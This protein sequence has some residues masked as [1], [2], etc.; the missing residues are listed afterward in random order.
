MMMMLVRMI[1]AAWSL[2]VPGLGG[3]RG[4]GVLLRLKLRARRCRGR[5]VG[6]RISAIPR[7]A[8]RDRISRPV[9]RYRCDR[10]VSGVDVERHTSR[11]GP[12]RGFS[13]GG[14]ASSDGLFVIVTGSFRTKGEDPELVRLPTRTVFEASSSRTNH[15]PAPADVIDIARQRSVQVRPY[16]VVRFA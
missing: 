7:S 8:V 9:R 12:A 6:R 3:R 5:Y 13:E 1:T 14:C 2:V 16:S 15:R 10:Q 4:E 11:R